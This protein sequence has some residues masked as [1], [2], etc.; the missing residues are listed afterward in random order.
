MIK[1]V[2][3]YVGRFLRGN[4]PAIYSIYDQ[5]RQK[6]WIQKVTP[7]TEAIVSRYGAVVQGGPFA[8]MVYIPELKTVAPRLIGSYE[9][10]LHSILTSV[11]FQKSYDH[12]INIG[13]G[14]G[15]Y[16]IGFALTV[17]SARVYAFDTYSRAAERC[18]EM[19]RL[20]GVADRVIVS[21][22]CDIW[23]LCELTQK[24][25]L[26]FMDCEGCELDLLNPELVPGL[27]QSDIIVELHDH[28]NP[29]ISG[30]IYSRFR[31]THDITVIDRAEPNPNAYPTIQFLKEE[32]RYLAVDEHRSENQK[33]FFMTPK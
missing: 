30:T 3:P 23:Q 31:L 21:G 9:A 27:G 18:K 16:A 7:I 12:I 5:Y 11:V 13:C 32:E 8:G 29:Q 22:E 2:R 14:E 33:W 28:L 4:L 24:K 17:K 20:N 25:S 6:K 26:L 1:R 19:A 15:Y 10:E